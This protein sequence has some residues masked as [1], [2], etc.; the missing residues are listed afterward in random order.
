MLT[1][2]YASFCFA[3]ENKIIRAGLYFAQS[4]I[5]GS[6]EIYSPSGFTNED[7]SSSLTSGFVFISPNGDL[8]FDS[9]VRDFSSDTQ[10]ASSDDK[11]TDALL[12]LLEQKDM[13]QGVSSAY[14]PVFSSNKEKT[15]LIAPAACENGTAYIQIGGKKY[16]GAIEFSLDASGRIKVINV[17]PLDEYLKGVLPNE[18]YSSWESEA[19]KAAAVATR[20]YTLKSMSGKHSSYGFDLCTTTDCQVYAGVTKVADSTNKAIDDTKGQ[21]LMY[22]D[23]LA[24]TV[25]HAISGGITESAAGA[26]GGKE[27]THPYLTQVYT[28]FELYTRP[29]NGTW[30]HVIDFDELKAVISARYPKITGDIASITTPNTPGHYINDLTITDTKGNSVHLTTSSM[31][32]SLFNKFALSANFTLARTFIPSDNGETEITVITA[33]GKETVSAKD[34]ITYKSADKEDKLYAAKPVWYLNGRGYGHGVGMSQY[35][36]QYAALQGYSYQEI[37]STYY[38]G[39]TLCNLYLQGEQDNDN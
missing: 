31:V 7:N 19:L 28:P 35:G 37:L 20:T 27:S 3:Q 5:S 33:Q 21:V 23:A 32:R 1:F 16:P 10:D 15:L 13:E 12:S 25:Y 11:A 29:S 38:P 4:A 9:S 14:T 39:T 17:V 22:N 8:F 30:S 36:A 34:G 24:E 2:L 18:V 26:W 6:V